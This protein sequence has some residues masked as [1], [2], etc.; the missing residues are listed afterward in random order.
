MSVCACVSG[1]CGCP[2]P[3]LLCARVYYMSVRTPD[4]DLRHGVL[5]VRRL[6]LHLDLR[7]EVGEAV[8]AQCEGARRRRPWVC[9]EN[10]TICS[11]Q[12]SINATQA[13]RRD[14]QRKQMGPVVINGSVHTAHK[15]HQRICVRICLC[16]ASC[17]NEAFVCAENRTISA[18]SSQSG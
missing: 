11:S 17:V 14:A 2:T 9:G 4:V 8:V 15:Q 5:F 3:T 16:L 13:A 10:G 18:C 7:L 12:G 1:L 6:Q